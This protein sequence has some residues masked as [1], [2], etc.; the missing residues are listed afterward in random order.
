MGNTAYYV[1][2]AM[3]LCR[4]RCALTSG[5]ESRGERESQGRRDRRENAERERV[6][7]KKDG[8]IEDRDNG[9]QWQDDIERF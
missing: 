4:A 1:P 9:D 3:P 8:T 5:A 2:S 7:D 6:C